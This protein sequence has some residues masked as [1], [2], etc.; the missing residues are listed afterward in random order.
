MSNT[1]SNRLVNASA[2]ANGDSHGSVEY[3]RRF[4]NILDRVI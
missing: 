4:R 3:D 2:D 1:G